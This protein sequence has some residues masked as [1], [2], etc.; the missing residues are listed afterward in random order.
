[1]IGGHKT[2]CNHTVPKMSGKVRVIRHSDSGASPNKPGF[3]V[4]IIA[5]PK[6]HKELLLVIRRTSTDN[7]QIENSETK[8]AA[9]M[10]I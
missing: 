3:S 9:F 1:L 10:G 7:V 2:R 4:K 8:S 5:F 6:T